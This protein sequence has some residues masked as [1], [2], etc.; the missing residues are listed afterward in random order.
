MVQPSKASSCLYL[1]LSLMVTAGYQ[2][3]IWHTGVQTHF[4]K[5]C[6]C[7]T[8][9]SVFG[10]AYVAAALCFGTPPHPTPWTDSYYSSMSCLFIMLAEDRDIWP[11]LWNQ[12]HQAPEPK[13]NTRC[14]CQR[15]SVAQCKHDIFS[16]LEASAVLVFW[17]SFPCICV[18]YQPK[19]NWSSQR[20]EFH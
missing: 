6:F 2:L 7:H 17:A 19:L 18:A 20:D 9:G 13:L 14:R 3:A 12:Q 1:Q 5:L 11:A 4:S 16:D 8:H 10:I 15:C